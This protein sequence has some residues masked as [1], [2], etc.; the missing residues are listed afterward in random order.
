MQDPVRAFS[1]SSSACEALKWIAL[2]CMISGHVNNAFFD[3][4]VE[5]LLPIGRLAMPI[6]AL[7]LGYNLARPEVNAKKALLPLLLVA[8]IAQPFHAA[9]LMDGSWVPLNIVFTYLA[10]MGSML[11]WRAQHKF[12]SVALFVAATFL[13]DYTFFGVLLLIA[14]WSFFEKRTEISAINLGL[15][16]GGLCILND[17]LYAL[18][19][20]AMVLWAGWWTFKVPRSKWTFRVIYPAHFVALLLIKLWLFPDWA[21]TAPHIEWMW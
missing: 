17:N 12:L 20:A 11:L 2:A 13:V 4:Q 16:L 14:S 19:G 18:L 3:H 21:I 10:G 5:W 15:A 1:L 9:L 8:L 7:V 6:F